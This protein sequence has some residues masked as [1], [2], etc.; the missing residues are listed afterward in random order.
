M[1]SYTIFFF[2]LLNNEVR[3]LQQ[4]VRSF[5]PLLIN[6]R[7]LEAGILLSPKMVILEYNLKGL[8]FIRA[9]A[10]IRYFTVSN[11]HNYEY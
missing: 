2:K 1:K 11:L 7:L 8:A 3:K 4:K 9:W 6:E 10:F 5:S